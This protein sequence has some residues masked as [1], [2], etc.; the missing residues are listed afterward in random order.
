MHCIDFNFTTFFNWTLFSY[1]FGHCD[2]FIP[3]YY[4]AQRNEVVRG[5]MVLTDQS[6]SQYVSPIFVSTAPL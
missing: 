6:F 1:T 2:D 5:I 3:S 4:Y